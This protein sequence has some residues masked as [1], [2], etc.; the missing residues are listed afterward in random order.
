MTTIVLYFLL[1]VG[2]YIY[3]AQP[4]RFF[5]YWLSIQPFVLPI[6]FVFF[7]GSMMP[8]EDNYMPKLYFSYQNTFS[9]LM[10]LLFCV[11][12]VRN[13][14]KTKFLKV[15]QFPL[16]FILS[17]ITFQHL[18]VGFRLGTLYHNVIDVLW[19]CAPFIL[20]LIDK[21]VRPNR[22]KL[23]RFIKIFVLVQFLFSVLNLFGFR[24]YGV[25]SGIF[26]DE[27]IC[28]TFTR[29]NHMTN[30]L[31]VFFY[32][33]SNEYFECK[34]ISRKSYL[35]MTLLIGSLILYSGSRMAL[36]LFAFS[37]LFFFLHY[38]GKKAGILTL[39]GIIS[40]FSIY[41]IGNDNFIGQKGDEGTG[42]ERNIIGIV[43]LSNSDDLSE[44]S[45][46]AMSAYILF[47]HFN[48]PLVGNGKSY[49]PEYY[50]GDPTDTYKN[51]FIYRTD[52]RL[53]FMLVDYGI[54]GL[55]LFFYFYATLFKGC[56]LYSEEKSKYLYVGAFIYFFLFSLTDNGFWD[57]VVFS[58]LFIYVFSV[59]DGNKLD[60]V[61][62]D[63]V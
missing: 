61:G 27:L 32:V 31:A 30:Y 39:I 6:I 20:L 49:R 2:M 48:S 18:L 50:Y 29:Y 19:S 42:I 25:I 21:R 37:L 63:N 10:L 4:Q 1:A 40:L 51:E 16:L 3:F 13:K 55:L 24:I 60:N 53:A 52:A 15:I 8:I 23:I 58:V 26:D 34:K 38:H 41:I 59:K 5:L 14:E 35:I 47:T 45:T 12:Y 11:S 7:G 28:G 36:I 17:F 44:G 22:E 57:Y 56:C 33:L 54:I 43:N 46:L 62:S 9:G